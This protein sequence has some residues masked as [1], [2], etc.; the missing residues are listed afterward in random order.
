MIKPA[1]NLRGLDYQAHAIRVARPA[2]GGGIGVSCNEYASALVRACHRAWERKGRIGQI[3]H[4]DACGGRAPELRAA[5]RHPRSRL[6]AKEL[7]ALRSEPPALVPPP[8]PPPSASPPPL[9]PPP[10][11]T[12]SRL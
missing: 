12:T 4:G 2:M 7:H 11:T 10:A 1:Y 3:D 9:P 6:A 5:G 8:S